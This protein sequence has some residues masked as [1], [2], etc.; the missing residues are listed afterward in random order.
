MT[1]EPV[2]VSRELTG[3]LVLTLETGQMARQAHGAVIATLGNTK[4]FAA[5]AVGPAAA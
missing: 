3:G 2:R 4:C 5:V 1:L